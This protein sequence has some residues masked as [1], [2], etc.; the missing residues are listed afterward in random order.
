MTSETEKE[1]KFQVIVVMGFLA[2][3]HLSLM[4]LTES[5]N[6]PLSLSFLSSK[7]DSGHAQQRETGVT[8]LAFLLCLPLKKR[9]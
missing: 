6:F 8:G 2:L 4:T 3:A 5:L 7:T 9:S 1:H